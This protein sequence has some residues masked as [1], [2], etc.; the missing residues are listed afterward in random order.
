MT[1]VDDRVIRIRSVHGGVGGYA[2][3]AIPDASA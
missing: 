1:P 2:A 3:F